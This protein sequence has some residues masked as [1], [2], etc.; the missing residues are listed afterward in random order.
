M[1]VIGCGRA[2]AAHILNKDNGSISAS[3]YGKNIYEYELNR[4]S[5]IYD[6]ETA[7]KK[8]KSELREEVVNTPIVAIAPGRIEKVTYEARAGF[9]VKIVHDVSGDITSD[10]LHMKRWPLVNEGDYVGAGTLLGYEG[11][12]GRS[13]GEHLHFEINDGGIK[14]HEAIYPSFNPF[15]YEEKA[16]ADNYKISSEYMALYRTISM[17]DFDSGTAKKITNNK[18]LKNQHP[19]IALV[20]NFENLIQNQGQMDREVVIAGE[21][22]WNDTCGNSKE[23]IKYLKKNNYHDLYNKDEFFDKELAKL[24]GYLAIPIELYTALYGDIC[25]NT[26]RPGSLPALTKQEL[27]HI[28]NAWLPSRYNQ[29]EVEWLK[30]NVFTSETIDAIIEAQDTYNVSPVFM[31]AVATLEQ[32]MGLSYYRDNNHILGK[33]GIYNIFSIKGGKISDGTAVE[34]QSEGT[35]W[36][37]YDSY[38]HAFER[39]SHLIAEGDY[40]FTQGRYTIAQI[41]P[42]YC[43]TG[44]PPGSKWCNDV[45]SV[46]FEIMNYYTGNWSSL[47]LAMIIGNFGSNQELVNA[48]KN[49]KSYYAGHGFKYCQCGGADRLVPPYSGTPDPVNGFSKLPVRQSQVTCDDPKHYSGLAYRTDCSTYV[50]WVIYEYARANGWTD[51]EEMFN[52]QQSSGKFEQFANNLKNGANTGAYQYMTLVWHRARGDSND[53]A[54]KIVQEGDILIY[55]Q[56]SIHHVD[57]SSGKWGEVYSC[58]GNK[59]ISAGEKPTGGHGVDKLTAII[60]LR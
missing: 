15:Y 9:M 10:Y 38:G 32:Q 47:P 52:S 21:L 7:E 40:Y 58:G 53:V 27:E 23:F 60:R 22:G 5:S 2:Y 59:G 54:K 48:I 49:C 37:K 57:F 43:P 12:T 31:L 30:K 8:L 56:G 51:L 19:R 44:N 4:L 16:K 42:V 1:P 13:F 28:L 35:Y 36:R 24:K 6:K 50:S 33:P 55:R 20:E 45:T 26:T 29:A 18:E 34:Y 17:V 3:G 25:V 46:A 41:G 14:P 11:C 39:F